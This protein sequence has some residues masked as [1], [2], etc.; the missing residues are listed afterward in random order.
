MVVHVVY[1][2]AVQNVSHAQIQTQIDVLNKDF[3]KMNADTTKI[4]AVWKSLAANTNIQFCLAQR[5]P[6]CAATNG[7]TRTS[8]TTTSIIDDDK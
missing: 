7:I 1:N 3:A 5:D 8:T 4:P 6:N 2:T